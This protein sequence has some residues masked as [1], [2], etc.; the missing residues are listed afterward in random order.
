M[1]IPL[2]YRAMPALSIRRAWTAA[3]PLLAMYRSYRGEMA[4]SSSGRA[5]NEEMPLGQVRFIKIPHFHAGALHPQLLKQQVEA[6]GQDL[7]P[8]QLP[9]LQQLPLLPVDL[10]VAVQHR[11][12]GFDLKMPQGPGQSLP[13][14]LLKVQQGIVKVQE[15]GSQHSARLTCPKFPS[16]AGDRYSVMDPREI[17]KGEASR[18]SLGRP[19]KI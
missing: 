3:V 7:G 4:A 12:C 11:R 16:P 6:A 9:L 19:G 5:G 18:K 10:V 14:R 13:F 8:G 1:K 17:G 15:Y 2:K